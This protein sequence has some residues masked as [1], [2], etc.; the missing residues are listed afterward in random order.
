MVPTVTVLLGTLVQTVLRLEPLVVSLCYR[1]REELKLRNKICFI[2][3]GPGICRSRS[4]TGK[5]LI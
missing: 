2:R 3:P 5:Q 1:E 4:L